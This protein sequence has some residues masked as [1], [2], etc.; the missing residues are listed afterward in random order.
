M[1]RSA[2]DRAAAGVWVRSSQWGPG[3][4]HLVDFFD[5]I[6]E[7]WWSDM[8]SEHRKYRIIYWSNYTINRKNHTS[9]AAEIKVFVI[10]DLTI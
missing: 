4:E 2:A 8:E 1:A 6:H 3:A 9:S 5:K 7:F 10:M